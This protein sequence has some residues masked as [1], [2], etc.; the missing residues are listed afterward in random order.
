MLSLGATVVKV[1]VT[2]LLEGS[3]PSVG[4]DKVGVAAASQLTPEELIHQQQV[5]TLM[6][7]LNLSCS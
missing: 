2:K 6:I 4:V 3:N 7:C 1:G 5:R